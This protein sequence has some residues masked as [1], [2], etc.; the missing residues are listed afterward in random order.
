MVTSFL[1]QISIILAMAVIFGRVVQKM[2]QPSIVGELLAG[3]VLGPTILKNASPIIF[4]KIFVNNIAVSSELNCFMQ[5]GMILF[6]FVSGL[7]IDTR[8]ILGRKKMVLFTSLSGMVIPLL[9]GI[10]T[11]SFL[12]ALLNAPA[13]NSHGVYALF[14][15]IALSISALPVIIKTLTDL[16]LAESEIGTI[17]IG[18]ATIDD[19]AGWTMFSCLLNVSVLNGSILSINIAI[20][21]L[22][23]FIVILFTAGVRM[24]R[25]VFS[26]IGSHVQNPAVNLSVIIIM[27]TLTAAIAESIGIHPFFAAFLLGIALKKDFDSRAMLYD[28]RKIMHMIATSFFAPL[29]FV[30]VGM[31]VNVIH[32]FNLILVLI[33][34]LIAFIGKIIGS[35]TGA[36]IGGAGRKDALVIGVCMNSRG[37]IEIIVASAAV[38][39]NMIGQQMYVALLIMA[40]ITSLFCGPV[41]KQMLHGSKRAGI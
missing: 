18:S 21:K 10:S 24:C 32:D 28:T 6:M 23:L 1:L 25:A 2:G 11:V 37:S 13:D 20:L 3:I 30:S 15:G 7:K 26:F 36:L 17:I 33:V 40:L 4:E 14:V 8:Y 31:K 39:A 35:S 19:I 5:F 16:N 9:L 27:L 34:L 22:L 12:P 41:V 29:Y 38:E